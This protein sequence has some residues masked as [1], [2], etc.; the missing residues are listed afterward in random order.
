[1]RFNIWFLCLFPLFLRMSISPFTLLHNIM[2]WETILDTMKFI[3]FTKSSKCK[4]C[5]QNSSQ[6][7]VEAFKKQK[8]AFF[9]GFYCFGPTLECISCFHFF[10]FLSVY[11]N[12]QDLYNQMG[13][14]TFTISYSHLHH[15]MLQI[16]CGCRNAGY[17][18]V[19]F[20]FCNWQ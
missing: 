16:A 20:T 10:M 15:R 12:T 19:S 13:K 8:G 18:Y 1:M 5:C 2:S 9:Y 3:F 6:E 7:K 11:L 17:D 14:D 4:C